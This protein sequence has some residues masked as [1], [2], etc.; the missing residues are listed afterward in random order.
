MR[1]CFFLG[2]SRYTLRR[3]PIVIFS[4]F[5]PFRPRRSSNDTEKNAK[6]AMENSFIT[7]EAGP[8]YFGWAF[9]SMEAK[10]Q[11]QNAIFLYTKY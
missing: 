1:R 6:L 7:L 9:S 5:L 3:A 2:K 4:L 11:S 10:T 8:I